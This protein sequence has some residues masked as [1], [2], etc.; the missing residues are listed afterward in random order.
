MTQCYCHKVPRSPRVSNHDVMTLS[1]ELLSLQPAFRCLVQCTD[2]MVQVLSLKPAFNCL[3]Q[4]TD[5]MVQVLLLK[6]AFRCLVQCTDQMVQ[7]LLLKTAFR[8]LV[9]C[10]DEMVQILFWT[11]SSLHCTIHINVHVSSVCGV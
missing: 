4:C 11:I 5:E 2:E 7:V 1:H 8:C 3:V 9:Q 6:T 10:T